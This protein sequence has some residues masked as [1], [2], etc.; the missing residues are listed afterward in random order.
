MPCLSAHQSSVWDEGR[1]PGHGAFSCTD[2]VVNNGSSINPEGGQV[3]V[4]HQGPKKL[5]SVRS[6]QGLREGCC[7]LFFSNWPWCQE[8]LLPASRE[9]RY[10][11]PIACWVALKR[12]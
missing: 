1:Q 7:I 10:Q 6:A 12:S 3:K 11:L 2:A 5:D 9:E 4:I 8:F